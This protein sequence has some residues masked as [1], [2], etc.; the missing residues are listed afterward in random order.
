MNTIHFSSYSKK[1]LTLLLLVGIT[2][3][4]NSCV[5]E[6]DFGKEVINLPAAKKLVT[7]NIFG[8]VIDEN[9]NPIADSEV[10]LKTDAGFEATT[11][12]ENGNFLYRNVRVASDGAFIKVREMGKFEGFRKMNVTPDSYNYTKIKLLDKTIIGTVSSSTGGT[13]THPSSAKLELFSNSVR[14]E[15]GGEYTGNVNVA[16]SWIDPTANDLPARMVGDLS[17]VDNQGNE[18]LLGTYGMLNVE[19]LADNGDEL[20]LKDGSPATLS[21]PVP[22]EIRDNAPATIPLWSYN[23]DLGVWFEEGSATLQGG[24]YVGD[25]AHFSSWN[26]DYKGERISVTGK[27][28]SRNTTGED[29][30]MPFLQIYVEV[31]DILRRGGYLDSSGEFEFYNFPAN[32][33]FTITILDR[34]DNVIFEQEYGPYANDTDLGTIVVSGADNDFVTVTGSATDCNDMMITEGYIDFVLDDLHF[35]YP[36]EID[37]TFEFAVNVCDDVSGEISVIDLVNVKAS[38]VQTLDLTSEV[39]DAGI[40]KACDELPMFLSIEVDDMLYRLFVNV[41]VHFGDPNGQTGGDNMS[42]SGEESDPDLN[43]YY[44]T[45][46][47]TENVTST[48]TYNNVTGYFGA[49]GSGKFYDLVPGSTTMEVTQFGPNSGD[50]IRGT[51]TGQ[52]TYENQGVTTQVPVKGVFKMIR[53]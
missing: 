9:N 17:G 31:E 33:V 48:G 45:N 28:I 38:P 51:F 12:D 8:L 50:L 47:Q 27:V 6:E 10:L 1:I 22:A 16:M 41:N 52:A 32:E 14:Y 40:L 13:A 11:T 42:I 44:F 36:L 25:V 39:V 30:V 19:L 20:Q 15:S 46:I 18:V 43:N 4:F 26:C 24:F 21:F 49:E 35:I 2:T 29:V 37:G 53:Q 23:E 3:F 7:T 34:C 5:K